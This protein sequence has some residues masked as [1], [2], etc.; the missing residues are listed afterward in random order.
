MIHLNNHDRAEVLV[1]ALPNI[2][3]YAGRTVVI[4]YGGNAMK[5]KELEQQ[6]AEDVVLLAAVGIRV[7]LV[8]GGGP[9]ISETMKKLG[10]EAV[11]RD[12]LR[13]TDKETVE[14]VQMVLAGRINKSLVNLLQSCG[15]K[16]VGLAGMDNRL[17]EAEIKD[18]KYGY[19]GKITSIHPE[20]LNDVLDHNYIPVI[21]SLGCDQQGNAY[22]INADTAAGEIAAVLKAERLI[23]MSDISGIMRDVHDPSS[24]ITELT[25]AETKQLFHSDVIT[26][27]MIPKVECCTNAVEH[28]VKAA[29][30][31]DGTIP[32]AL[33]MELLTD[34]GAGTM[35]VKE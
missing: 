16:A 31:L 33:L 10:K 32:H 9:A 26:G 3:H 20:L 17:I 6:V 2:Q 11:F 4:K 8:H 30:I 34:E 21:A 24:L 27:G 29:V 7:V 15:G 19:V 14:I 25:L 5:S 35:I 18:E 12:G 28:G 1:Q 22:N 13:V 23:M